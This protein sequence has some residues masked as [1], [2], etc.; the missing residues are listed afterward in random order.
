MPDSGAPGRGALPELPGDHLLHQLHGGPGE[1][2]MQAGMPARA[3][4]G[5]E[6]RGRGRRGR[7]A[8][9]VQTR[10]GQAQEAQIAGAVESDSG[11]GVPVTSTEAQRSHKA[12]RLGQPGASGDEPMAA[13][14]SGVMEADMS[15]QRGAQRGGQDQ[16][17][18]ENV[19]Q[20]SQPPASPTRGSSVGERGNHSPEAAGS[21]PAPA[22][23]SGLWGPGE[24]GRVVGPI[25]SPPRAAFPADERRA[26]PQVRS[27]S[28]LLMPPDRGLRSGRAAVAARKSPL[29]RV[30][31]PARPPETERREPGPAAL[32]AAFGRALERNGFVAEG[33]DHG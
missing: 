17:T 21:N 22:S 16:G 7:R 8:E 1:L 32:A 5:R 20:H 24:A 11:R 15:A 2:G 26:T 29:E 9:R 30:D 13:R 18:A 33:A 10:E 19:Q 31:T 28:S 14:V 25:I 3:Y 6:P 27:D 4:P 23:N 12:P